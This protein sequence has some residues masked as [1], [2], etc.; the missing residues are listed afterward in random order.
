MIIY[1]RHQPLLTH[2]SFLKNKGKKIIF[3]PTMGALHQGHIS[4]LQNKIEAD[5][6][7]V[8]SIFVNPTQFNNSKDFEKYP[9]SVE[10][11]IYELEKA[12]TN[13]LFLPSVE[14]IYPG[15]TMQKYHYDLGYLET[16]LEG[17]YRPGHFQ[18]VCQVVERLIQIVEP[19]V[20]ILGQKDYQQCMVINKLINIIGVPVKIIV[21]ETTREKDGLAMSSRNVR[22]GDTDRE[23]AVLIY[24]TMLDI[25]QKIKQGSLMAIKT[26]A[27]KALTTAGFTVDYVE[28][29]NAETLEIVEKW[30]NNT[31]LVILIA[32]F[33]N[34]VRLI[35]N[36]VV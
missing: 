24:K 9:S 23:K 1:K 19:D 26:N 16:I 4:L 11:D 32:A 20:L 7:I 31:R 27:V 3:I 35:D 13:I 29:A 22:L 10:K 28:I 14:E 8:S 30:N 12:G 15:G 5:N 25:K 6:I 17:I 34:G 21:G 33:I 18:G 2:L 36:L